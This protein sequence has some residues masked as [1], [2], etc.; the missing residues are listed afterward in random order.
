[1]ALKYFRPD[2][3]N[4][5]VLMSDGVANEGITDPNGLLEMVGGYVAQVIR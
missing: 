2:T 3:A 1:M 5:V 4:R